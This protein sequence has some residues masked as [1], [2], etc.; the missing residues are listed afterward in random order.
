MSLCRTHHR[1]DEKR[2]LVEVSEGWKR[3]LRNLWV[4][5]TIS[6]WSKKGVSEQKRDSSTGKEN[7]GA[8]QQAR[9]SNLGLH[10]NLID[11]Y[12]LKQ[13]NLLIISSNKI[14]LHIIYSNITTLLIISSN[15]TFE[16]IFSSV[17]ANNP[18]IIPSNNINLMFIISSKNTNFLIIVSSNKSTLWLPHKPTLHC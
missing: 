14:T 15:T 1:K 5:V 11:S 8:L 6:K 18:I 16:I 17:K 9:P 4:Y 10:K 12:L 7:S 2:L 13:N 3:P